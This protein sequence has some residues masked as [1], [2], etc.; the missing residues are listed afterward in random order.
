[1]VKVIG[2][3]QPVLEFP[4]GHWLRGAQVLIVTVADCR[5]RLVPTNAIWSPN[6][7]VCCAWKGWLGRLGGS[8]SS[9]ASYTVCGAAD[10]AAPDV[11]MGA[12]HVARTAAAAVATSRGFRR[13]V[14]L[15]TSCSSS[16]WFEPRSRATD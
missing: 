5:T 6:S 12:T 4:V 15:F 8:G 14:I 10:T 2:Y 9:T 7:A 3:C 16:S 1:M 13:K 11:E